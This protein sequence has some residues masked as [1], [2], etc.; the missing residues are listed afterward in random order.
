MAVGRFDPDVWE[1]HVQSA[2]DPVLELFPLERIWSNRPLVT[3][4]YEV[5]ALSEVHDARVGLHVS[6]LKIKE[7]VVKQQDTILDQLTGE[8]RS[9]L[10]AVLATV[11]TFIV[12]FGV[13]PPPPGSKSFDVFSI[14]SVPCSSRLDKLRYLLA[15]WKSGKLDLST[16]LHD[17]LGLLGSSLTPRY[18]WFPFLVNVAAVVPLIWLGGFN[19][20]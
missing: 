12:L 10:S 14:G 18:G 13:L 8:F 9:A 4:T 5:L 20:S 16:M 15:E 19:R 1:Q 6:P 7:Q 17:M 2:L 3:V 11:L